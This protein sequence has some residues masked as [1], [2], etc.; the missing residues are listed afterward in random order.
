MAIHLA[1]FDAG[2]D[3]VALRDFKCRGADIQR[4]DPF[5]K[6]TVSGR[7]LR[8]LYDGRSIGYPED[9]EQVVR[10]KQARGPM[11]QDEK[12]ALELNNTKA[13]LQAMLRKLD[14]TVDPK[15]NKSDLVEEIARARNGAAG[16]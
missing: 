7:T 9:L 16:R 12:D 10:G 6:S 5:D 8:I 1:P 3:L 13:E 2:R 15:W 4:G 11:T 14:V